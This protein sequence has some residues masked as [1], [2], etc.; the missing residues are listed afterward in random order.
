M[1]LVDPQAAGLQWL[2]LLVALVLLFGTPAV[3]L[4]HFSG[5]VWGATDGYAVEQC[6]KPL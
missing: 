5:L 1:L 6:T 4:P 2:L 3:R